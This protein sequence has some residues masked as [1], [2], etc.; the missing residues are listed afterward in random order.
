MAQSTEGTL[1]WTGGTVFEATGADGATL[2][3]DLPVEKGG[4]GLG[5]RPMELLLHALGACMATTLVQVLAKQRLTLVAYDQTL[6]GERAEER[7]HQ[8]T[9]I[10]VTHAF[11]GPGLTR[12]NLERL[13]ALVEERYC[14]VAATL[15]AG[16][17]EHQ[18][19]IN[20]EATTSIATPSDAPIGAAR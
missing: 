18:V 17:V 12:A 3:I 10:V 9:R 13:V 16:L 14:S 8:Y 15:P 11:R 4:T 2:Q 6:R 1:R 20:D 7:P 19:I 5:F